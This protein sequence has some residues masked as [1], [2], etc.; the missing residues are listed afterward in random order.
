MARFNTK[1]FYAVRHVY[2]PHDY[3]DC[4]A[5]VA[6]LAFYSKRVTASRPIVTSKQKHSVIL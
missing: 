6:N 4:F 2:M 3:P 1:T 5:N